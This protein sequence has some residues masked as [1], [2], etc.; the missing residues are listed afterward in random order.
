MLFFFKP[1]GGG[2]NIPHSDK[3][4]HA[5]LFMILTF[6]G[7]FAGIKY[8][9]QKDKWNNYV[10]LLIFLSILFAATT[11]LIQAF[12]IPTRTGDF[13]DFLADSIGILLGYYF[14]IEML[15]RMPINLKKLFLKI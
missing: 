11:E 14:F 10:L 3:V 1:E 5:L 13:A 6:L 7:A 8:F 2:S 4:I 9:K 15:T 12:V